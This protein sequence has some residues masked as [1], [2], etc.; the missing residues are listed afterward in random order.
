M[1]ASSENRPN[2]GAR[3]YGSRWQKERKEFLE[4]H[5]VCVACGKPADTVDHVRPHKGD[6]TLMWD[7]SNWQAMCWSCHSRKTATEDSGFARRR[8]QAAS[9]PGG[10]S[11]L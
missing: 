9:Y 7:R 6:A 3:G 2:S 1:K 8:P 11:K 10:G 4:Q 5:H